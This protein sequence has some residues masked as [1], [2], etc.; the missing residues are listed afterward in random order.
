MMMVLPFQLKTFERPIEADSKV[1]ALKR[2]LIDTFEKYI[3][4]NKKVP[5]EALTT[6][7]QIEEYFSFS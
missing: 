2:N 7:M 6:V 4:L 1:E 5:Q 3:K